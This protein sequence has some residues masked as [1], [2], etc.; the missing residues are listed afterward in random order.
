M[1]TRF[2]CHAV[3]AFLAF[4]LF[5]PGAEQ[6][7]AEPAATAALSPPSN[8]LGERVITNNNLVPRVVLYEEKPSDPQGRRA[9]GSVVW[10]TETKSSDAANTPEL[11]VRADIDIPE[12]KVGVIL[13]LRHDTALTSTS[14]TIEFRFK[15]PPDFDG[16]GVFNVPGFWM[17]QT[18]Q[19][20]GAAL[21]GLV[22]KV[23]SGY[24]LIGLSDAPADREHNLQLIKDRPW[25]DVPIVYNNN[26]RAILAVE[27]G[28]PGEQAFRKVFAA[29]KE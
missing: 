24:F 20:R 19:T 15:L 7:Y 25:F 4:M 21:A 5:L 22:V 26:R 13:R 14:Y 18:M 6:A 10:S 17:K 16:G 27:K 1:K 8:P 12:R 29:W 9:V 28:A 3:I 11:V 2:P 23:T